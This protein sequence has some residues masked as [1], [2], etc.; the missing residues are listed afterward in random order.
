MRYVTDRPDHDQR[1]AINAVKMNNELGWQPQESFHSG[2]R[3]H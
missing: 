2:L 3:N 1:Y